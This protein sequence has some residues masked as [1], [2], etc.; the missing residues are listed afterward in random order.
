MKYLVL[1]S[2]GQIGTPLC[3]YLKSQGN[4]V[5][6]YDIEDDEIDQDLRLPYKLFGFI[7]CYKPDF[8]FFLAFDVG[9]SRYLKIYQDTTEFLNNNVKIML[10]TFRALE[11]TKVPFIFASSQMSNMSHSSYG[12]LKALGEYYTKILDGLT[13][14]FWN[15]YGIETDLDKAHVIT[16]FILKAKENRMIDLIT[17]GNETRQFLHADDCSRGL[18]ILSQ[19]FNSLDKTNDYHITSFEWTSVYDIAK[20][21]ADFYPGTII[22]RG[23]IKDEVQKNV[24]NVPSNFILNYWK[25]EISVADGIKLIIQYYEGD[26]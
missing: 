4:E 13:V 10:H 21:I 17:D 12:I 5:Y 22:Q 19:D 18:Y 16:D 9:G 6:T 3:K 11:M 15:V 23:S 24:I 26:K 2:S 1:G 7:S 8:I 20:I 25:P 14:K